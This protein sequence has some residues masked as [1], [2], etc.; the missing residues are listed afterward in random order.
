MVWCIFILVFG[1]HTTVHSQVASLEAWVRGTK[2]DSG[3]VQF[4]GFARNLTRIPGDYTYSM[5]INK[6]DAQGNKSSTLQSDS[7]RLERDEVETLSVATFNKATGQ[8]FSIYLVILEGFD[9]VATSSLEVS[10][11]S[12]AEPD[13]PKV[14]RGFEIRDSIVQETSAD[15]VEM[16]PNA[17]EPAV[18]KELEIDGL[19]IDET[20]SKTGRDFYG[21]FYR[22]WQ[23]PPQAESFSITLKEYP[24]RGRVSRVGIEVNG[25]LVFQPV[26]QPRQA[27]LEM[28]AD[29]AVSIVQKHL[30]DQK[31]IKL[32]MESE[33]QSGSGLF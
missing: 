28:V 32:Q 27:I 13:R 1:I 3:V 20:R 17:K 14:L 9:V 15:L 7:F 29:Q 24:T 22:K 8:F 30:V 2:D 23:A 19:I 12:L 16:D 18:F 10:A 31:Q 26:L 21:L 33:D 4:T 11:D 6:T 5:Q 25:N